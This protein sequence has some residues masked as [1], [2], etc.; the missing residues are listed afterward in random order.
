M[1]PT[2]ILVNT[3][4]GP[5]VDEEALVRA[6][7]EKWIAGAALDVVAV[8]PLPASSPLRQ[9]EQVIFTPH[10]GASSQE[11]VE[12]LAATVGESAA[13]LVQGRWPRFPVNPQVRPRLPLRPRADQ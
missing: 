9:F 5:V 2:A 10:Y 13:D 3:S 4:R 1:K 12:Q 11:S 7:G 8:E 6:L